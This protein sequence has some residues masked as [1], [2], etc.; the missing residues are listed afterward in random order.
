MSPE[1]ALNRL[2]GGWDAEAAGVLGRQPVLVVDLDAGPVPDALAAVAQSLPAVVVGVARDPRPEPPPFDIL[3]TEGTAPAEPWVGVEELDVAWPTVGAA[4]VRSAAAAVILVQLLRLNASLGIDDGLVAES[5]AYSLLQAGP[6]HQSW[7]G[8]RPPPRPP[9][10]TTPPTPTAPAVLVDRAGARLSIRLNRPE[11]HNAYNTTMRDELT[12]ALQLGAADDSIGRVELAGLGPSFCSGGDLNE[13][14]TSED[15]VLAH[16]IRTTRNPAAWLARVADRTVAFVH[17]SCVGAGVELPAFAG[18][19]VAD[20]ETTFRL[21]EVAMGL[22]P[23]AGGAV[24][25]PRRIGRAR[26][27]YLA[28]TGQALDA[29]TAQTWGLVDEIKNRGE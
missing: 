23:G 7:L 14:G 5:L 3:L 4:V 20:P 27:A 15:P 18:R 10:L 28:V 9:R 25:L 12:A 21:P 6:A 11:V 26:T 1:A 17:G 22:I 8:Q 24:S 2:G 16:L 29:A 13:F 19:V